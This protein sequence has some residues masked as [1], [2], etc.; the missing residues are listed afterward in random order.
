VFYTFPDFGFMKI[1]LFLAY[2]R[3]EKRYSSNTFTAYETDLL[4]F[5]N[6]L[7]LTYD[8]SIEDDVNY[9][10][11]RAWI[12]SLVQAKIQA[13]SIA[14]K[15]SS[16]K[17]FY[18]YLQRH[19]QVKVNPVVKII[20]PKIGKRLTNYIPEEQLYSLFNELTLPNDFEGL[21]NR[22]IVEIL[23]TCG[24]RRSELIGLEISDIDL[25]N[26][27]L[28]VIGKGNKQRLVPFG[29]ALNNS[30]RNYLIRRNEEKKVENNHL[31]Y[32]KFGN[33]IEPSSVYNVVVK[34]LS[35][36]TSIDKKSPHILR[37]SF[38]THLT[39]H[40]A[41]LNS[42]KTLLGH[43]SLAATQIYTHNTIGKLKE[44]YEIAHPKSGS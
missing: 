6:F 17:S 26:S 29:M 27:R 13:K 32:N 23:Y 35:L 4:Q 41:D 40:G 38:A 30:L 8:Q 11:V 12:V 34:M 14:R 15:V 5:N 19:G 37:H 9:Q 7:K 42:V 25:E 10:Q 18:K 39:E 28:K 24:L 21:K 20:L 2:I 16:L 22:L 43:S 3:D 44:A 31:F 36:V 33:K 1:A